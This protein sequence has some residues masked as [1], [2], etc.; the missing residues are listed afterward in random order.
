MEQDTYACI[1]R[2]S[3]PD[4]NYKETEFA[5]RLPRIMAWLRDLYAKEKLVACGG[6][7]FDTRPGALIIIRAA[8]P[9]EARALADAS[10]LNEIG[11]TEL[12]EWGIY[13]ANLVET[14]REGVFAG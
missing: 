8:S 14:S 5:V 10:P 4:E 6:G 11:S 3:E 9:E 7:S 13:Y 2:A 12:L 1:W